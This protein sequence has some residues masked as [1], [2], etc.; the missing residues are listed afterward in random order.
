MSKHKSEDFK[1]ATVRYYLNHNNN[2][3]HTC[4]IFGCSPRSLKRWINKY[5]QT[6]EK[7][8]F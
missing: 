8:A 4:R 3:S 1:I 6:G 2:Y 7:S 5:Q